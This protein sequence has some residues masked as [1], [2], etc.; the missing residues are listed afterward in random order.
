MTELNYSLLK[1]L[2]CIFSPSGNERK[3]RR[4][5]KR[6]ISRN[7]PD[8]CVRQDQAGNLYVTR[9][10]A[11][12]YPCL[13]AHID[14]VQH[15]HPKDFTCVESD[16]VIFGYSH[17][18]RHQCGLGADDK[19]GVFIALTCLAQCDTLKCAFFVGEEV[20]CVGS[21]Q[22][23]ADFF[24]DCR[25]CLQ[26]D[27]RGNS[28]FVTSIGLSPICSD[29]FV[30]ATSCESYG[31]APSSG[32]MTDVEAL[33]SLGVTAS[34]ANIS[35]GYYEPHTDCEFTSKADL[36][37]CYRFVCH[38]I[39]SCTDTYP[40]QDT[41]DDWWYG[42]RDTIPSATAWEYDECIDKCAEMLSSDPLLE[43]QDFLSCVRESF[44]TLSDRDIAEAYD[45]AKSFAV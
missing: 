40:F 38:I 11:D 27:R 29:D 9:G 8:A 25:F 10:Q 45:I 13:C 41:A 30:R 36:E 16:E 34:C 15:V 26:I 22:A 3:M 21:S 39:Q 43:K 19:N 32:L 37:K 1:D 31:Y 14:Q 4:F 6:H 5:I 20:G 44:P 18:L 42:S 35:C 17:K 2:Y 33:R 24:A 7:I 12:T 28:D 23:D